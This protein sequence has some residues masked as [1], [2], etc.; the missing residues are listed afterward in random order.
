MEESGC[1]PALSKLSEI[2]VAL[3]PASPTRPAGCGIRNHLLTKS[4]NH[5]AG[6][7]L[8]LPRNG[9]RERVPTPHNFS[10][11]WILQTKQAGS[12]RRQLAPWA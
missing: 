10:A 1:L 11:V 2:A 5:T 9:A 6:L 8:R 12:L 3:P 7:A 4:S